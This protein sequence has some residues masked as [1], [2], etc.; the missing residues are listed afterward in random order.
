MNFSNH[1][2]HHDEFNG[3]IILMAPMPDGKTAAIELTMQN[4]EM[5]AA[6]MRGAEERAKDDN[7]SR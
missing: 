3:T 1:T 2:I 6:A 5:I 4:W 7:S